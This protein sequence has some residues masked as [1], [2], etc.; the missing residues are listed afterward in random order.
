MQNI[1]SSVNYSNTI[2]YDVR[3]YQEDFDLP[4]SKLLQKVT[5]RWW[6]ILHMLSSIEGNKDCTNLALLDAGKKELILTFDGVRRIREIIDLLTEFKNK[7]DKLGVQNDITITLIIPTFDYF[8]DILK[9]A[10]PGESS[11]IKS[12]KSHMLIKLDSRY[13]EERT[14]YLKQCTFLDPRFKKKC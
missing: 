11:M 7:T 3:K 2:I 1:V 12:M 9:E 8:R 6:S 4:P 10:K 13:D 14:E 5:T